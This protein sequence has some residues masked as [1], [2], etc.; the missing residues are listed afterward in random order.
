MHYVARAECHFGAVRILASASAHRL[1]VSCLGADSR[2]VDRFQRLLFLLG[3]GREEFGEI[4]WS[5][6][7]SASV[8]TEHFAIH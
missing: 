4:G 6:F 3:N 1:N 8:P 2:S 7:H 5:P